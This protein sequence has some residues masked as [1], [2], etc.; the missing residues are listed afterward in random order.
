M[1]YDPAALS[2]T[3]CVL[4]CLTAFAATVMAGGMWD[5]VCGKHDDA[6]AIDRYAESGGD[7]II[8]ART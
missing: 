5:S 1:N 7:V 4:F 2:K 6:T 8:P 3:L